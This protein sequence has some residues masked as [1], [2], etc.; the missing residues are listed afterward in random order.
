MSRDL[1]GS[2]GEGWRRPAAEKGFRGGEG[3][4][5]RAFGAARGPASW[6]DD[7]VARACVVFGI[8][9]PNPAAL[10]ELVWRLL[11][12]EGYARVEARVVVERQGRFFLDREVLDPGAAWDELRA[13]FGE[14]AL[15]RPRVRD[16]RDADGRPIDDDVEP[17]AQ[18]SYVAEVWSAAREAV[19][20][21]GPR[22]VVFGLLAGRRR[23]MT[24][25]GASVF[26]LLARPQDRLL[27]VRVSDPRVEGG[28]GFF[29]PEQARSPVFA[30]EGGEP[31][32]PAEIEVLLV[33][34]EL[35]RLRP[36]VPDSALDSFGGARAQAAFS[37]AAAAP[38]HLEVDLGALRA[39]V[40]GE[41]IPFSTSELIWYAFLCHRKRAGHGEVW[42]RDLGGLRVFLAATGEERWRGLLKPSS[43]YL[44]VLDGRD[45]VEDSLSTWRSYAATRVR[46][47]VAPRRPALAQIVPRTDRRKLDG[48]MATLVSIPLDPAFIQLFGS[49]LPSLES[50]P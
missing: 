21:A 39:T 13:L 9:G 5:R 1:L 18:A 47:F 8:L 12:H 16:A 29:F 17:E 7:R 28:T 40:D 42:T 35:P 3:W 14:E 26:Q 41:P 38:P 27:D 11:R 4:D 50:P 20:A 15:P 19:E 10:T 32:R 37:L 22:P 23:T 33:E 48:A 25:L 49:G 30:R 2:R 43:V 44:A 36:F 6:H 24:A 31:V 46:R 45:D 34:L